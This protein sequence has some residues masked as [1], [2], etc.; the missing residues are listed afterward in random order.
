MLDEDYRYS[1]CVSYPGKVG[2]PWSYRVADYNQERDCFEKAHYTEKDDIEC[3]GVFDP[4]I[5]GANPDELTMYKAEIRKWV[6]TENDHTKQWS[7]PFAEYAGEIYE[8]IKPQEFDE[9]SIMMDNQIRE[10]LQNG[11]IIN[12]DIDENFLMVIGSISDNYVVLKCNKRDFIQDANL[13]YISED[14]KDILHTKHYFQKYKIGKQDV[15]STQLLIDTLHTSNIKNI[16]YFY[17]R[18]ELK[19]I[20]DKFY[21]RNAES[22][23][24]AFF[25]KYFKHQKEKYQLTRNE[26]RKLIDIV[27]QVKNSE[28]EINDF[29]AQTGFDYETAKD[30][31]NQY[32]DDIIRIFSESSELEVMIERCLMNNESIYNQCIEIAKERWLKES[33][34]DREQKEEEIHK[35]VI[36]AKNYSAELENINA[37]IKTSKKEL[38]A[39]QAKVEEAEEKLQSLANKKDEIEADI[40]R[41]LDRFRDDIVYATE[42]IGVAE[43][44][45]SKAKNSVIPEDT[46]AKLFIRHAKQIPAD[47]ATKVDEI[48]DITEFCEELSDNISRHF[49]EEM[50]LS[51]TVLSALVNN[52]AIILP[53]SLGEIIANDVSALIDAST[54]EYIFVSSIQ[55]DLLRIINYI[56]ESET[57]TVYIDGVLNT[58][59]ESAFIAICKN[60]KNKHLFFGSGTKD[61]IY[62]LSK[63]IWNYAIYLETESYV[64]IPR[65]RGW[66][67]GTN[68]LFE[69]YSSKRDEEVL[70]YYKQMRLFVRQGLM[71]NKVGVDYAY[72]LSSYNE[73]IAGDKIG[74]PLLYSIYLCGKDNA[75]DTEEYEEKLKVCK[76]NESDIEKLRNC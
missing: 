64:C 58:Y 47:E 22:Y 38:N 74:I 51:A 2:Q 76:V 55:E 34:K 10:E 49:E 32:A 17:I 63:N 42:L 68:D 37:K 13:Y 41:N 21:I 31:I 19:D 16:R 50:E 54:A 15:V 59:N 6:P 29:F 72:L 43:A 48:S 66:G 62:T 28:A 25:T 14:V 18:M 9:N 45:G 1:L 70:K 40:K 8:V 35:I 75:S 65:E 73:M 3:Y 61:V 5:I 36:E 57:K 60:C 4:A 46:D 67:I 71:T 56:N 24:N 53:D 20:F 7:Y 69:I 39:V 30:A 11:I 33:D 44:V 12:E 52:K 23:T 26:I 27:K